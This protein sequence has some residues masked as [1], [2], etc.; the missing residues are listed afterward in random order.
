MQLADF[1]TSARIAYL[2]ALTARV[3]AS[4]RALTTTPCHDRHHQRGSTLRENA[5]DEPASIPQRLR[6][7]GVVHLLWRTRQ[8]HG[9]RRMDGRLHAVRRPQKGSQ[10]AKLC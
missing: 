6:Q 2:T 8:S 3:M 10:V 5:D 4:G 1:L 9:R 7:D